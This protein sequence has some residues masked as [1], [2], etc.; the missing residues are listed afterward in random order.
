MGLFSKSTPLSS[1]E[2]KVRYAEEEVQRCQR[3]LQLM[4]DRKAEAKRSGNYS[5]TG[6]SRGGQKGGVQDANIWGAEDL[7]KRAKEKLAEAK[8]ELAVIKNN[9][10]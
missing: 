4:K 9:N 2:N 5:G 6:Y 10:K 3:N 7:L 8:K 1:A